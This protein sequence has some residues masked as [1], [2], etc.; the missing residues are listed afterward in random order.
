[1]SA[2]FPLSLSANKYDTMRSNLNGVEI[3][4][5]KTSC[6]LSLSLEYLIF[7]EIGKNLV[8]TKAKC[9]FTKILTTLCQQ[10]KAAV[11]YLLG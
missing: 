3:Y 1:M 9:N 8:K 2:F 5:Y 10:L 4:F 7:K 11:V 6:T